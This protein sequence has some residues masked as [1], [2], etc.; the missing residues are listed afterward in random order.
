MKVITTVGAIQFAV[1]QMVEDLEDGAN[2]NIGPYIE[3]EDGEK[4]KFFR[5][6]KLLDNPVFLG[7]LKQLVLT[8][9]L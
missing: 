8:F 4:E 9:D 1:S 5:A 7:Q 6:K 2:K 3:W